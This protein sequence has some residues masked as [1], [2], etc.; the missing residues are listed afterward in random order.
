VQGV[1]SHVGER[2]SDLRTVESAIKGD[3]PAYTTVDLSVGI[4]QNQWKVELFATNLFDANGQL[5]RNVSCVETVCGDIVYATVIRPRL[6]G[7]KFGW[8]F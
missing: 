6:I 4:A 1:V 5:N 7:L 2:R 8:K 3:L